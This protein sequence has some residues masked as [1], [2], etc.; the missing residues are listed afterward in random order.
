[1][2]IILRTISAAKTPVKTW[3][4]NIYCYFIGKYEE[5]EPAEKEQLKKY[6]PSYSRM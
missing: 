2:A 5:V 4:N 6:E 3:R 1:M